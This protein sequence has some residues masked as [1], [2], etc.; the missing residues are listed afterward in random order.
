MVRCA[1]FVPSLL[2]AVPIRAPGAPPHA[3]GGCVTP[4]AVCLMP[5]KTDFTMKD[6]SH[7]IPNAARMG[8][9]SGRIE[10]TVPLSAWYD[11]AVSLFVSRGLGTC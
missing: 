2:F 9:S 3:V 10:K 11:P 6:M 7:K 4:D 5:P 1:W 8:G